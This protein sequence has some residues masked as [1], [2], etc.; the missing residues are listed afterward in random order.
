MS[1]YQSNNEECP[2]C[3]G[4]GYIVMSTGEMKRL[5]P[6]ATGR[7]KA[8]Y[9]T[10]VEKH[11]DV[12]TDKETNQ[13]Q[14]TQM[15]QFPCLYCNSH[16]K[17]H[18]AMDSVGIPERF[19]GK[20]LKHFN[21]KKYK[22]NNG[23]TI[24]ITKKLKL[25]GNMVRNFEEMKERG[26]GLYIHGCA[27]S[28]KT[29]LACCMI[30]SLLEREIISC[31]FVKLSQILDG[32]KEKDPEMSVK[33]LSRYELL[34]IDDLGSKTEKFAEDTLY[35]LLDERY[36]NELLTVFT[37]QYDVKDLPYSNRIKDRVAFMAV[38]IELP[39]HSVGYDIARQ[40]GFELLEQIEM[41]LNG[42][43]VN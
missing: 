32:I 8:I 23:K 2:Y 12:Y 27:G 22:D 1:R 6:K 18:N 3:H 21:P 31:K 5:L 24:D 16:I 30:N 7:E 26:L 39:D 13:R 38:S 34:V 19:R 41:N 15:N 20:K 11:D 40:K 29:M 43:E 37:S 28:G 10:Q 4:S 42:K 9:Q 25:V 14:L 17:S 36:D 35:H 33:N